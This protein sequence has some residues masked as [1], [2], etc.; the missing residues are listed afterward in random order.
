[1]AKAECQG[2]FLDVPQA[3]PS[4]QAQCHA[5]H[6]TQKLV[7]LRSPH[8]L[9]VKGSTKCS[10]AQDSNL[11]AT[12]D[13]C[14]SPPSTSKALYQSI[15]PSNSLLNLSSLLRKKLPSPLSRTTAIHSSFSCCYTPPSGATV[16]LQKCVSLRCL[17]PC[18]CPIS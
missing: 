3:P 5:L 12:L 8:S 7:S 4:Q 16:L 9:S 15:L 18:N 2:N 6:V 17:K 11:V 10:Y 1:M 13:F 14:L